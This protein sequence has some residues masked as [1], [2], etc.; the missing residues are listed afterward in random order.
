MTQSGAVNL[1]FNLQFDRMYPA[2][3]DSMQVT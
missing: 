1:M 2:D 3:L